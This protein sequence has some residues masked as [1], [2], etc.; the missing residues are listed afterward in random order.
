M[1]FTKKIISAAAVM[2]LLAGMLLI[3]WSGYNRSG[4]SSGFLLSSKKTVDLWYNDD[5]LTDFFT[6]AAVSFNESSSRYRVEPKYVADVEFLETINRASVENEKIPDVYVLGNNQL[7]KAAAAGL[8]ASVSSDP[9][10]TQGS[11]FPETAVNAV[12]YKE[13]QM[14][15]PLYFETAAFLYNQSLLQDMLSQNEGAA[16]P[17]NYIDIINLSDH[18]NAPEGVESILKWDVSDIFYNYYFV[19][20]YMNVGGPA[21]DDPDQ[22]DIYNGSVIQCLQVYQQLNQFFSIDAVDDSYDDILEDFAQGRIVF[23]AA[24]SDA[25]GT[26]RQK[27]ENGELGFEYGVSALPALTEQLQIKG[28]SVTYCMVINRYSEEQEAAEEFIHYLYGSGLDS[29]YDRTGKA[30]AVNGYSF[31]DSHMDGFYQ[32]YLSSV[33][34]TKMREASN[35]W[36]FLE[37]T[38]SNVWNGAD[39]NEELRQLYQQTM[40]QF[41]GSEEEIGKI[42]D[43]EYIDI[44]SQLTED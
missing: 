20:N 31:S 16:A 7:E 44:S 10:F 13:E 41:T 9:L 14:G 37:N 29:F 6:D 34:I 4:E 19:G 23:T 18:Y 32:A 11:T 30:C 43:P 42:E 12:T 17:Q 24:T 28:M 39:S 2:A 21:G 15:Y 8:A 5:S 26:L 1:S 40:L 3:A 36:M 22:L 33:P 35:F 27:A 38:L 25:V